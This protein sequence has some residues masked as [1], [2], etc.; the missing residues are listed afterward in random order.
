LAVTPSRNVPP[1]FALL[2]K[3]GELRPHETRVR[4]FPTSL[5]ERQSK[6]P[7]IFTSSL[8]REWSIGQSNQISPR[9]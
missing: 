6:F 8:S 4:H 5:Y 9:A 1:G 7:G 3:T 2:R